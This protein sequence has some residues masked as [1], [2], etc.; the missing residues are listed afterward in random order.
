MLSLLLTSAAL[1]YPAD[2]DMAPCGEPYVTGTV[3]A[4]GQADVPLDIAPAFV[5]YEDCGEGGSFTARLE[6]DGQV[7]AEETFQTAGQSSGLARLVLD[8][9]LQANTAYLFVIEDSWSEVE[10]AFTSGEGLVVGSEPPVVISASA[11]ASENQDGSYYVYTTVQA[12]LG[13]DPDQSSVLLLVDADGGILAASTSSPAWMSDAVFTET[14]PEEGCL[15]LAQ[16]DGAGVRSEPLEACAP[17]EL[18]PYRGGTVGCSAGG[19]AA[20]VWLAL[21]GLVALRR[22]N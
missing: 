4:A 8:A 12:E 22:R 5:W 2:E 16:E 20:S 21:A 19:L 10:V 18:L 13:Q 6:Q 15:L 11:A 14:A 3:P 1:A 9:D 7:L 17:A